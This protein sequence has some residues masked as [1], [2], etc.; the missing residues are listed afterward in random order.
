MSREFP[1]FV[2]VD[3]FHGEDFASRWKIYLDAVYAIYLR[4]VAWGGLT[5]RGLPVNCRYQ[6]ETYGKH[7]AFWH[8]MQEGPIEDERTADMERCR[9]VR[10][11]AW[12]IKAAQTDDPRVRVFPEEKR[13]GEQP[14]ALW[15]EEENYLVILW[16]RNRY[17]LL[18]TAYPVTYAGTRKAL[19]RDWLR[20][21]QTVKKD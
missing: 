3:D 10:W 20:H 4:E 9:R 12:V 14:W 17:F 8:M 18:K 7:Y 2:E 13:H 16:E 21:K 1:G 6:P 5:F 15:V 19:M 11:I